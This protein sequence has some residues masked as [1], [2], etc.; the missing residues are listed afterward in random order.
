MM[1]AEQQLVLIA[2]GDGESIGKLVPVIILVVFSIISAIAKKRNE[3]KQEEE[4]QE[5]KAALPPRKRP[6]YRVPQPPRQQPGRAP[7]PG[8]RQV[9]RQVQRP[10][11]PAQPQ[12]AVLRQQIPVAQPIPDERH[13]KEA[14]D[15]VNAP[16]S[17]APPA[18]VKKLEQT[19]EDNVVLTRKVQPAQVLKA[20]K[21][22]ETA[23]KP[24]VLP[25]AEVAHVEAVESLDMAGL[26][27]DLHDPRKLREA[28]LF[29]EIFDLPLALR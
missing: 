29:R 3:N 11:Q 21:M 6:D 28:M 14:F 4:E 9:P 17:A 19:L 2:A 10:A 20:E 25:P 23:L 15:R 16:I 22:V 26:D 18:S 1:I 8:Q 5:H 12:R 13:P 24:S 7:V 27:I